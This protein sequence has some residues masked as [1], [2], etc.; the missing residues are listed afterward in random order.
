MEACKDH[1]AQLPDHFG[2]VHVTLK[3]FLGQS[4]GY[5]GLSS[6]M[7]EASRTAGKGSACE[8]LPP[9]FTEALIRV[10]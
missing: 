6:L 9:G 5:H 1:Q 2:A 4:L 8:V 10:L 3:V 7:C